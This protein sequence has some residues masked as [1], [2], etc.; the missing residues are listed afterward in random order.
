MRGAAFDDGRK[1]RRKK[2]LHTYSIFAESEVPEVEGIA[3]VGFKV[4]GGKESCLTGRVGDR[5]LFG[6]SRTGFTAGA[7]RCPRCGKRALRAPSFP[8]GGRAGSH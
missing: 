6:L 5:Q 2:R 7:R 4:I 3:L 8:I 1:S